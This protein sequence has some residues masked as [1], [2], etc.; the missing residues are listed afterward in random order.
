MTQR[1]SEAENLLWM[2]SRKS[3]YMRIS[4]YVSSLFSHKANRR[5]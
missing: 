1:R 2:L 3:A 4:Q 5:Q